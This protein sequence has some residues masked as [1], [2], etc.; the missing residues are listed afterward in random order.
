MR[1]PPI[2]T[3]VRTRIAWMLWSIG[4]LGVL[5]ARVRWLEPL[6]AE[7]DALREALARDRGASHAQATP[8]S[9]VAE[10]ERDP[11]YAELERDYGRLVDRLRSRL[12]EPGEIPGLLDAWLRSAASNDLEVIELAPERTVTDATGR[13][14]VYR[15]RLLGRYDGLTRWMHHLVSGPGLVVPD[16]VALRGHPDAARREHDGPSLEAELRLEVWL[17]VQAVGLVSSDGAQSVGVVP[18][19]AG[20]V[21][22]G[23]ERRAAPAARRMHRDPFMLSQS[24][25]RD[26]VRFDSLRLVG[27]LWT[28][29]L[30]PRLALLATR[31]DGV[32]MTRTLGLGEWWGALRLIDIDRHEVVVDIDDGGRMRRE[33][34]RMERI[35]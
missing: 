10:V 15:L 2:R 35:P 25:H 9:T 21:A 3:G 1:P 13:R 16:A 8:R 29:R 14:V 27:L 32:P 17:E 20:R 12:I 30:Q 6:E 19:S 31:V 33:R 18:V 11:A 5:L 4:L 7:V 23:A 28:G 34:L 22:S 24:Q 26:T